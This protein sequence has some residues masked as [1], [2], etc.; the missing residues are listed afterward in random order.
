MNRKETLNLVCFYQISYFFSII[1]GN[2]LVCANRR[3]MTIEMKIAKEGCE[4]I[5]AGGYTK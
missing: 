2:H 1:F 4:G 3:G 5:G